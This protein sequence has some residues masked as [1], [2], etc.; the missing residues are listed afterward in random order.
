MRITENREKITLVNPNPIEKLIIFVTSCQ[1]LYTD[2]LLLQIKLKLSINESNTKGNI[3]V[4]SS[5]VPPFSIM[6]PVTF[7]EFIAPI[8]EM[9]LFFQCTFVPLSIV[10]YLSVPQQCL[11]TFIG[12]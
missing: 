3:D 11:R 5:I 10:D 6:R 12:Y 4:G 9:V 2:Q 1:H 7:S 8:S